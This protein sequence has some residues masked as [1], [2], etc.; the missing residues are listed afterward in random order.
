MSCRDPT[1]DLDQCVLD[2]VLPLA[3]ALNHVASLRTHFEKITD[4]PD[5]SI[6]LVCIRSHD[7]LMHS[8]Q[9]QPTEYES[10]AMRSTD[11]TSFQGDA[12]TLRCIRSFG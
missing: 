11:W 1:L 4:F 5:H 9:A 2:D 3:G 12:Q 8:S 6:D 10:M 7:G